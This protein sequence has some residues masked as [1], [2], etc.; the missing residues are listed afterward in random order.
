MRIEYNLPKVLAR[1][2]YAEAAAPEPAAVGS[3]PPRVACL[4]AL[5]HRFERLVRTGAV[6]NYAE[7]AR[8]GGVSRARVSQI[9]NLLAVAPSIQEQILFLPPRAAGEKSLTERDL[10]SIVRELRWDRQRELFGQ[11]LI[12]A[13]S[14]ASLTP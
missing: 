5:A 6:R 3:R 2:V 7:I 9:L 14:S 10:R 1:R 4:L 8:L 13:Q 12:K 11:M